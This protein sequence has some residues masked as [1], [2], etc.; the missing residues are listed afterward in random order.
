GCIIIEID[1]SL[2]NLYQILGAHRGCDF[3][4]Q[5]QDDDAKHVSKVFYCTYKSDRLV[6]KNGW[7]RVDIKDGWFKSKG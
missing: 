1:E 7:K 2:P 3:L 5:P 6:Q 4:K